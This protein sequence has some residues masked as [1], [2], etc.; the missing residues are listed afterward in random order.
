MSAAMR[1]IASD[2]LFPEGPIAL[3][4][5]SLLVVEIRRGTLTRIRPDGS[6]QTIARTGGGPNGAAIGPDGAC[7]VCNNGGFAWPLVHGHHV[8]GGQP[9]D[10]VGGS[11]QR[12][13]LA[14]GR[15][16]TLYRACDGRPLRGPNDIVFDRSGGFWFTDLGKRRAREQDLG[17]VYYAKADGSQIREVVFPLDRPNGIGLSPDEKTLYVAETPTGRVWRFALRAP[18]EIEHAHGA[19]RD[20]PGEVLAGLPGYQLFDSLAV[21]AQGAVC[22]ATLVSGGISVFA[23]D[24]GR[25]IE[26][27]ATGDPH[28]TNIAFGGP[29]LRTAFI[30]LSGQ[31]R[32][33][34][35]EWPRA[36]APLAYLND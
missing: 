14:S 16:E 18:G 24:D 9:E 34:A 5:G 22:V 32:V 21:E 36:G 33:V 20:E 13:D 23:P 29:G 25:L 1:E 7:Y 26:Q 2:L 17:A 28:T 27:V 19:Y 4:D 31:G 30:T 12:I 10:Y 35:M 15:C 6:R 3:P 8:P 11:I